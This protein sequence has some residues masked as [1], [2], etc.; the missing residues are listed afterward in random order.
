MVS[1]KRPVV[2]G[3][4]SRSTTIICTPGKGKTEKENVPGIVKT[5]TVETE[6]RSVQDAQ[7]MAKPILSGAVFNAPVTLSFTFK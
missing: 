4:F 7:E 1:P 6:K 3:E 5:V 2:S